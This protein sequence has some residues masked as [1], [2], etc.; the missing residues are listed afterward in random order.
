[1]QSALLI[2]VISLSM[3]YVAYSQM[4]APRSAPS[5]VFVN[6]SHLLDGQPA[7]LLV[8]TN[9]SRVVNLQAIQ[10]DGYAPRGI[11]SFDGTN[12]ST[13]QSLCQAGRTTFFSVF[14]PFQGS[15]RVFTDGQ[16]WISG[17]WAT[18][19]AVARGWN[20]V[21]IVNGSS[22]SVTLP[23]GSSVTSQ[24]SRVAEVPVTGQLNSSSF[25]FFI[26]W[27]GYG[28]VLLLVFQEGVDRLAL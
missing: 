27:S 3:A 26:P 16:T 28:H 8:Q 19:A 10:I 14:V 13:I 15:L 21:V 7:L 23:D 25:R 4:R 2:T 5:P 18:F 20:E 24:G 1:M 9:A 17:S 11:L 22:C 12:Y 6:N